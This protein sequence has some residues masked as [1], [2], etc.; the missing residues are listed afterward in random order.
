MQKKQN[1]KR[2]NLNV[3]KGN[4][5]KINKLQNT[6]RQITNVTKVAYCK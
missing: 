5:D 6:K 2:Q 4:K 1:K 3:T